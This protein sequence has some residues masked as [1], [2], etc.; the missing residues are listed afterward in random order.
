M[1]FLGGV[2][3]YNTLFCDTYGTELDALV[4]HWPYCSPATSQVRW[5]CRSGMSLP[6]NSDFL[7]GRRISC[8]MSADVAVFWLHRVSE[9]TKQQTNPASVGVFP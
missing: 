9:I 7:R 1:A 2:H 5:V 6:R 8:T 3:T 4:K